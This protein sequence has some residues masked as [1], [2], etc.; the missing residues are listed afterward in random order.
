MSGPGMHCACCIQHS[1][2]CHASC[3]MRC[4]WLLTRL[5]CRDALAAGCPC[6]C[7]C[8]IVFTTASGHRP[9][10]ACTSMLIWPGHAGCVLLELERQQRCVTS[11]CSLACVH[12][13]LWHTCTPCIHVVPCAY[14]GPVLFSCTRLMCPSPGHS[15]MPCAAS[16]CMCSHAHNLHRPAAGQRHASAAGDTGGLVDVNEWT[17][18]QWEKIDFMEGAVG[19]KPWFMAGSTTTSPATACGNSPTLLAHCQRLGCHAT[20]RAQSCRVTASEPCCSSCFT[21]SQVS[22]ADGPLLAPCSRV[23]IGSAVHHIL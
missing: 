17:T 1:H 19:L 3:H 11:A 4:H 10:A 5:A 14:H 23:Y 12:H 16:R 6:H 8:S 2:R 21:A 20:S 18:I 22:R 15:P 13:L 9:S 7:G